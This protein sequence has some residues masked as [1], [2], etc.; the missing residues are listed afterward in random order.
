[1]R[2]GVLIA[3]ALFQLVC[4]H[5]RVYVVGEFLFPHLLAGSPVPSSHTAAMLPLN[6]LPL[7]VTH[8]FTTIIFLCHS[9]S[10]KCH[11][12]ALPSFR[13]DNPPRSP[14]KRSCSC[15]HFAVSSNQHVSAG[16]TSQRVVM[17]KPTA[18]SQHTITVIPAKHE[19]ITDSFTRIPRR[20]GTCA[21]RPGGSA[22]AIHG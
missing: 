6:C 12:V 16:Y 22:A 5:T 1:M 2:T 11:L 3:L 13:P 4:R 15:Y 19:R 14:V 21:T 20:S 9:C 7:L 18:A 10:A 8:P 17:V